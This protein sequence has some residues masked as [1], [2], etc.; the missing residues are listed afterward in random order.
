MLKVRPRSG[1]RSIGRVVQS[2]EGLNRL[3]YDCHPP[4]P[5]TSVYPA[6]IY[7]ERAAGKSVYFPGLPGTIFS[8]WG[9]SMAKQLLIAAC[10]LVASKTSPMTVAA[11]M[12][13]EATL[14]RQTSGDLVAHLV[15]FQ[16]GLARTWDIVTERFVI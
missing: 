6:A 8:L 1:A 13:V 2:Q 16:P 15:N 9:S 14:Y 5:I 4:M 12:C 7:N 11:P 10:Q 3:S